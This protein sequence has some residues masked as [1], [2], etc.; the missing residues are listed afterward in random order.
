MSTP[1]GTYLALSSAGAQIKLEWWLSTMSPRLRESPAIQDSLAKPIVERAQVY[2]DPEELPQSLFLYKVRYEYDGKEHQLIMSRGKYMGEVG[3][4][5]GFDTFIREDDKW[6]SDKVVSDPFLGTVVRTSSYEELLN[7]SMSPEEYE[8]IK[9]PAEALMSEA[10]TLFE[11]AEELFRTYQEA[12]LR[13]SYEIYLQCLNKL[14]LIKSKY[15]GIDYRQVTRLISRCE[16][17]ISY[18]EEHPDLGLKE[19][20]EPALPM[21]EEELIKPTAVEMISDEEAVAA[22]KAQIDFFNKCLGFFYVYM[23]RFPTTEEGL[24]AL[25]KRPIGASAD[26]WQGPYLKEAEIPLDPWGNPYVYVHPG[27]IN[28]DYDIISYG[29]DGVPGGTGAAAD[30]TN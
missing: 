28:P 27:R 21:P 15:P 1:E 24:E 13:E 8:E 7:L 23:G 5:V 16:Q 4:M 9:V 19:E 26:R 22:A 20:V 12:L 18:L 6:L 30:I 29:A 25:V 10:N 2:E 14:E 3:E 11:N 17:R